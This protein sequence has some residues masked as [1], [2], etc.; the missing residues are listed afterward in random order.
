M[1]H[2]FDNNLYVEK[3]LYI[4]NDPINPET[5]KN[6][7]TFSGSIDASNPV[8]SKSIFTSYPSLANGVYTM[9]IIGAAYTDTDI[10]SIDTFRTI[11]NA[12]NVCTQN[13]IVDIITSDDF[14]YTISGKNIT[15]LI[16]NDLTKKKYYKVVVNFII[17]TDSMKITCQSSF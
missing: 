8:I 9:S 1:S 12:N 3:V 15:F 5:I 6:S 14:S 2:Y 7:Y 13:N 11:R 16:K 10:S 17:I 4:S